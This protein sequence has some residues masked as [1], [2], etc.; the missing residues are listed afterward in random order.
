MTCCFRSAFV[1]L[2]LVHATGCQ[3]RAESSSIASRFDAFSR[4]ETAAARLSDDARATAVGSAYDEELSA[5]SKVLDQVHDSDLD[6]VFRAAQA[7]AFYTLDP[8]H[9]RD[10]QS[11]LDELEARGLA[12]RRHHVHAQ[13]TFIKARRIGEALELSRRHPADVEAVPVLRAA[14]GIEPGQP[15]EWVVDPDR[16][17]LLRRGVDLRPAQVLVVSHPRCHFSRA[18]MHDI[19]ADP[20]L[21]QVFHAHA[22][23][24]APPGGSFSVDA[25]QEWNREHQGQT[26]ALAF[27]R[28]EWPMIDS[29]ETPSFY[30]LE[31]GV[32]MAKVQGWPGGGRRDELVT[33]LRRVRLMK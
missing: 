15:T 30:F 27:R 19:E 16:P 21:R 31:N 12:S 23:W 9:V 5:S 6:L 17:E 24:L 22:R 26:T 29:W 13:E 2:T 10:M 4:R 3:A 25:I 32:V 33:A 28:E 18:A 7:A 8:R 20:A 14:A 1:W 11:A